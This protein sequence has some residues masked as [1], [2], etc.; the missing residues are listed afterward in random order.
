M[1]DWS[2]RTFD[3]VSEITKQV[4][5]LS[6]GVMALTLTFWKDFAGHT[7]GVARVVLAVSWLLYI[8]SILFGFLTLM[9]SAGVQDRKG[10]A[11]AVAEASRSDNEKAAGAASIYSDNLRVFGAI[12]LAF[13]LVAIVLT[14]IAG[15]IAL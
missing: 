1:A 4:I 9:A 13:F 3:L 6:T 12:Q 10:K 11:L 14:V 7:S 8:L 5:T 15:A 2:E